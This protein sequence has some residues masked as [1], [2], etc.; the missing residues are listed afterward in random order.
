MCI[1][2]HVDICSDDQGLGKGGTW[3]PKKM[4]KFTRFGRAVR[5]D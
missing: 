1:L 4:A 5:A 3:E 2:S